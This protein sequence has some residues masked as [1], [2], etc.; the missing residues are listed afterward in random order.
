MWNINTDGWTWGLKNKTK[1]IT[2]FYFTT[3]KSYCKSYAWCQ[4]NTVKTHAY[5]V[6]M[7]FLI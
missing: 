1:W 3:T 5:E 2:S 4:S 7:T 6:S